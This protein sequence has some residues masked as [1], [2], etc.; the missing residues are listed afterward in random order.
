MSC[1]SLERW[2]RFFELSGADIFALQSDGI[3]IVVGSLIEFCSLLGQGTV[4]GVR[5]FFH[6][7]VFI[8]DEQPLT[9]KL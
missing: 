8:Y 3:A 9:C 1:L 6:F 5:E 4:L 7:G 2:L